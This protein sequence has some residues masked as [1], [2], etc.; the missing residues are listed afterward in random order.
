MRI[1][2]DDPVPDDAKIEDVTGVDDEDE[3]AGDTDGF[4]IRRDELLRRRRRPPRSLTPTEQKLIALALALVIV[5]AVAGIVYYA[6][7]ERSSAERAK[8]MQMRSP[9]AGG[10]GQAPAG[11][12]FRGATPGSA[13]RRT[14]DQ[15][16]QTPEPG[17]P[18]DNE[19]PSEGIH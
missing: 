2:L 18:S 9:T 14:W 10:A 1:V 17:R 7:R 13:V 8:V 12:G 5:G 11:P 6:Q 19:A 15:S 16:D 4:V 3:G